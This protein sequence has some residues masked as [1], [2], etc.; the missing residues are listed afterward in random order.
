VI[1]VTDFPQFIRGLPAVDV[2]FEG[3]SGHLLQGDR[4]QVVFLQ[5][6]TDA[7][8]PEHSHN[9]QWELVIDG[10]VTLRRGGR[11][12]TYRAGDAFYIPSGEEHGAM[13]KAG[14]R[15]VVFFDQADRYGTKG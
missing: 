15:A 9:A 10:E 5:F 6:E 14:Y 4:H 1:V 11:T 7:N 12:E 13:V 2:P 3:V 8:V